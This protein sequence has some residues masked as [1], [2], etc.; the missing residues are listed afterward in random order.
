L[1]EKNGEIVS[2][3]NVNNRPRVATTAHVPAWTA[4]AF[5][6]LML[7][8]CASD[9][10]TT[11]ESAQ[12]PSASSD[13]GASGGGF[14]YGG[15]VPGGGAP[16]FTQPAPAGR[17]APDLNSVPSNVPEP[18]STREEREEAIAGLIADR[19]NARYTDQGGRTMPVAVRPLVDAPQPEASNAVARLDAPAPERPTEAEAAPPIP[20]ADIVESDVGPRSFGAGP[21]RSGGA[22]PQETQMAG[23]PIGLGGFRPLAEFSTAAYS[24]S[25]LVGTMAMIGGNL[26]PNDRNVLNI[27]ARQQIDSRGRGVLRVVGHGTGGLERAVIAANELLRLGVAKNNIFVG[28]DNISGPTEV[29]FDRAK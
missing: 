26:T 6:A 13:S 7:G 19:T 12:A 24:R 17:G 4:A 21:R 29:F 22:S 16:R 20:P 18:R 11:T 10:E 27:T 3:R 14:A 28:V 15:A 9:S 2:C 8:A 1:I 25:T 5:A 23:S